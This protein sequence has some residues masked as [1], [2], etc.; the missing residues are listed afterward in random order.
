[1]LIFKTSKTMIPSSKIFSRST[2]QNTLR[3]RTTSAPMIAQILQ[4]ASTMNIHTVTSV[5]K[6]TSLMSLYGIFITK[7]MISLPTQQARKR[8]HVPSKPTLLTKKRSRTSPKEP[9]KPV[10][11]LLENVSRTTITNV[12][13]PV[14]VQYTKPAI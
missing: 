8:E 7:T 1:M 2:V 12:T 5:R 6:F 10:A 13:I 4:I 11:T 3:E 14:P 9:T